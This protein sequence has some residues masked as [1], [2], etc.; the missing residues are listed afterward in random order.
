MTKPDQILTANRLRDGEVVYWRSGSWVEALEEAEVFSD[1]A[2]ADA[3]LKAA[4]KA[5][6]DRIVVTPYLF[7]VRREGGAIR[8]VKERE[9][10][11]AAGPTVRPDL[12]K[13]SSEA[14]D[15]SL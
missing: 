1:K 15:V 14:F 13:Q 8:P 3:A 12:G 6:R 4:D 10:I 7:D 11:R 2:A 5:V 9:I